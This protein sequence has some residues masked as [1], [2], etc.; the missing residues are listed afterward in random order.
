M[1]SLN[2]QSDLKPNSNANKGPTG[3]TTSGGGNSFDSEPVAVNTAPNYVQNVIHS[4]GGKPHGKNL[5]EGDFK[6]ESA[7]TSGFAPLGSDRDP[8]RL[9]EEQFEGRQQVSGTT[10]SGS[11]ASGAAFSALNS[12]D[13]K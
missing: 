7:N 11:G 2:A 1:T 6:G 9:A 12:E 5:K 13:K 10:G 4:G 8:S 3:V